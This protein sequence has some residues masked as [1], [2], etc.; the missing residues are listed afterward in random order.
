MRA[1]IPST[2]FMS[3]LIMMIAAPFL[4]ISHIRLYISTLVA[5]SMPCV[6]SSNMKIR[7]S[8]HNHLAITAF[9]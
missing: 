7:V 5:A 6:G 2:S 3:E 4:V 9:C 8:V 1:A